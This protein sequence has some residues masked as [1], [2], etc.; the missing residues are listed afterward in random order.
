MRLIHDAEYDVGV[1]FI[2]CRK[3]SPQTHELSVGRATLS[4]NATI[5][6][7]ICHRLVDFYGLEI[8]SYSCGCR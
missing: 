7:S 1:T 8:C 5:P 6:A 3:L 4:D 2:V